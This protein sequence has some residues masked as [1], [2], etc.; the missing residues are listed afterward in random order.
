MATVDPTALSAALDGMWS[1][2]L[3]EML[4]RVAVLQT[5]AAACAAGKVKQPQLEAAASAAH[6]LAGVLGTFGLA[7]GTAL[8]RELEQLF[9]APGRLQPQRLLALTSELRSV[10]ES[11]K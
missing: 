9:S 1:K 10:I 6:K 3:P 2:F 8:A 5:T 4:E 7:R 11:R